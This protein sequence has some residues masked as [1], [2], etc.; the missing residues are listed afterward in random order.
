MIRNDQSHACASVHTESYDMLFS[1]LKNHIYTDTQS[2]SIYQS[3][4]LI[5]FVLPKD[6]LLY[7]KPTVHM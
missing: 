7:L 4:N 1:D 5:L 2:L 6:S 3:Y